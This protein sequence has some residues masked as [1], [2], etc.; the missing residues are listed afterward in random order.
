MVGLLEGL[1]LLTGNT[2]S[3]LGLSKPENDLDLGRAPPTF[4]VKSGLWSVPLTLPL[5]DPDPPDLSSS[6]LRDAFRAGDFTE[7]GVSSCCLTRSGEVG[8]GDPKKGTVAAFLGIGACG[9]LPATSNGDSGCE[10]C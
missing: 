3:A 6:G 8:V 5:A 2:A 7:D 9:S 1:A 10:C 4:G